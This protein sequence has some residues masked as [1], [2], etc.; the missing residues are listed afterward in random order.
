MKEED[1]YDPIKSWM[2]ERG[3][4]VYPEVEC[5]HRGGRADIVVTNG[6][7][8]GVVEMKQSLSLDL[9][10]Q[11]LRWRGYAHYI[12]I[13]I[14]YQPKSYK[15][16]V[17]MVLRDYGIGVLTISKFGS[18]WPDKTATF[19]RRTLP[20]LKEALTEHHQTSEVKGGQ[21]GGGYITPYRITMN[22]IRRYLNQE[23][24]WRTI[25]EI[26]DHC[27]THYVSP[28]ASLAKALWQFEAGWCERKKE[29]GKLYFR[30]RTKD[31]GERGKKKVAYR[32]PEKQWNVLLA[33]ARDEW[34]T[35]T[36][37]A[38]KLSGVNPE[39][40]RRFDSLFVN[41]PLK[42]LIKKGWVEKNP[43]G[44]GQYRLTEAGHAVILE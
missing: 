33:L 36:V 16:F 22:Q 37:I 2:E 26:L 7:L 14:P 40:A 5:R 18:V 17:T 3:F 39:K 32:L 43:V 12:W 31:S 41:Q 1:M 38:G 30:V 4:T 25:K 24:D 10:E 13:A 35:P 20:Y 19:A 8:V 28:R 6:Q 11:A 9:I 29:G 23:G 15:K 44:R 21:S 27:E 42:A 34:R